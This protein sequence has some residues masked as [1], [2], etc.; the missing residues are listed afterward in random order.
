MEEETYQSTKQQ[1]IN[2]WKFMRY[3]STNQDEIPYVIGLI[4]L[5]YSQ[6]RLKTS[7]TY[8]PPWSIEKWI[9]GKLMSLTF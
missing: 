2:L 9:P 7:L 4:A 3:S 6:K 8:L 1:L 5:L